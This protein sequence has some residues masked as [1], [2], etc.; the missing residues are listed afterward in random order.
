MCEHLSQGDKPLPKKI[1]IK[2][3]FKKEEL[4]RKKWDSSLQFNNTIGL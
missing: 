3:Y 4:K 2:V 1:K